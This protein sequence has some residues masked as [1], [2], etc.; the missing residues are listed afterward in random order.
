MK[1]VALTV[2]LAAL[3][4]GAG[5]VAPQSTPSSTASPAARRFIGTWRLVSYEAA[6]KPD[7]NRGAN[8]KGVIYYDAAGQ[9][10]AQIAPDRP[11][12]SWP[13]TQIPAPEQAREAV[14]GYTAYFGTYTVDERAQ[15]VTHHRVAALNFNAVDYV[16]RYQFSADGR[17]LVLTPRENPANRITWERVD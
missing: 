13:Q 3:A 16:R 12:P 10:A 11:R 4:A 2:L 17:R 1:G 6:G 15:T 14:I 5:G 7:P 9:M 8:P